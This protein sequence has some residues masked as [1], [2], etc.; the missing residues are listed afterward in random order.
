MPGVN[1]PKDFDAKAFKQKTRKFAHA[2]PT[3][4]TCDLTDPMEMFL[5]MMV[6]LPGVNGGQQVMPASY[7]MLVS[8]HLHACGAMLAC[9]ACGYEKTPA[10]VYVPPAAHDPHWL[11][12]PG[13]WVSPD[14]APQGVG[15]AIDKSL[16]ALPTHQ[17]E[18]LLQRLLKLRESGEL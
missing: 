2:L 13:R 18:A 4:D 8:Q 11:T 1:L 6:A 12:S 10:K 7:N 5:W 15:N 16:A 9:E 3:R 17:K 14:K